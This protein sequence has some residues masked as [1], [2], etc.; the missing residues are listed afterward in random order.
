MSFYWYQFV[1][2][3]GQTGTSC[4]GNNNNLRVV[5]VLS[6]IIYSIGLVCGG[7]HGF[8]GV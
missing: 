1:L 6:T 2:V 7:G 4:S 8:I 3:P 5:V